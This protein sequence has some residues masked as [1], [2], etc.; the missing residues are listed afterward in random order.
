METRSDTQAT[1]EAG[2]AAVG[3]NARREAQTVAGPAYAVRVIEPSP[4]AVMDE[5][6]ADDPVA[7][8]GDTTVP[9][10]SPI[11]DGSVTWGDWVSTRPE[12][13]PWVQERW[14][15]AYRRIGAPPP[16]FAG[17]RP[18]LHR[19]AVYVI[20]PARRRVN[21]KIGLR[22]TFRG[23]GTP[24][25]G[26]DEQVRVTDA[27]LVR[28]TGDTA[29]AEAISTLRRAAA[30]VLDAEPDVGWAQK[31]DVPDLGDPDEPLP[32]DA[33]AATYLSDWYGFAFSVLEQFRSDPESTDG[34]RVQLWP[35]HFDVG[36]ECL[37]DDRRQRATFGASP[38]DSAHPNPYLY[39]TPWHFDD[40]R[41]AGEWNARDFD[42]AIMPVDDLVRAEDQ[43]VAALAFY[44]S[45]RK[46]LIG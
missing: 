1:S 40:V 6:F 17:T 4:P 13:A 12:H 43:R 39:V 20:S 42:G 3:R 41:A 46:R 9:G 25:F 21:G 26:A 30:F 36:F 2:R 28:Q 32:V 35:E 22:Y 16:A 27:A 29:R 37:D 18:A 8:S 34:R 7:S 11:V 24:F 33:E 15:G 14:L 44:R 45:A 10:L 31:F 5:W 19:L 38:G 23:F